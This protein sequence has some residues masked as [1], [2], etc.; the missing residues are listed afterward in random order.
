[1]PTNFDMSQL[2]VT[3]SSINHII[4]SFAN[5]FIATIFIVF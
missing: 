4:A 3:F 1:M 5:Q 2:D